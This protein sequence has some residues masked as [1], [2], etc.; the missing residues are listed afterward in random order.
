MRFV[1]VTGMSGAGRSS[2]MKILEDIGYFCVDNLPV[3]LIPDLADMLEKSSSIDKA[4]VGID[5]RNLAELPKFDEVINKEREKGLKVEILFLDA[6]DRVLIQRY[7]ETRRN[8]PL[9]LR[10]RIDKAITAERNEIGFI[11]KEADYIIDTSHMLIRDLKHEIHRIFLGKEEYDNFYVIVLSFGFKYG[12]PEDSDLVFDVRFLPNPFYEADLKNKTGNDKE[13][14]DYVMQAP[15][16]VQ[17]SD[18]LYSMVKF[19]IPNYIKEGKNM[20]VLSVGCTG[21]HHRSVTIANRLGEMMKALPYTVKVE[22]RD[23]ER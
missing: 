5:I 10:G 7:S 13:V 6:I 12:I 21:G 20:L 18:M 22:H 17:F 9:A 3:L 14:Y 16:A 23:I 11:K 19:L 2:V 8:H 1:I 4:A 15:E